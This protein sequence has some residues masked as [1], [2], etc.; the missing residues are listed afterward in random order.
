MKFKL[1]KTSDSIS[2]NWK[3]WVKRFFS[4][5]SSVSRPD[6]FFSNAY[7][8]SFSSFSDYW[9][10]IGKKNVLIELLANQKQLGIRGFS[11]EEVLQKI[12]HLEF[13]SG[14]GVILFNIN[15]YTLGRTLDRFE[16]INAS[17]FKE[18]YVII[19]AKD[20]DQARKILSKIPSTLAE[21]VG[22]D[23]GYIFVKNTEDLR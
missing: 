12:G 16:G 13:G 23:R 18:D 14:V 7:G 15:T 9:M 22:I 21:G 4:Q 2:T 5:R 19:P 8:F 1:K 20:R 10:E 17:V 11:F 3:D 6:L